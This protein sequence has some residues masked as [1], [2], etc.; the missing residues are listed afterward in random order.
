ML[1]EIEA[2]LLHICEIYTLA[3]CEVRTACI[4]RY[5]GTSRETKLQQGGGGWVVKDGLEV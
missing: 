3:L 5:K 1:T 4:L 2:V